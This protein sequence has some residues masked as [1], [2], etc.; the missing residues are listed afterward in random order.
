MQRRAQPSWPITAASAILACVLGP[1]PAFACEVTGCESIVSP[2]GHSFLRMAS[3]PRGR[4]GVSH[5][6][7]AA[8]LL[9]PQEQERLVALPEPLRNPS[10]GKVSN[11]GR[12]A[13]I[14]VRGQGLW[15][16]TPADGNAF[17]IVEGSV[18]LGDLASLD[19]LMYFS[20]DGGLLFINPLRGSPVAVGME[21]GELQNDIEPY[22]GM[23]LRENLMKSRIL[24][25]AE[26]DVLKLAG[27]H[28]AVELQ[29][30]RFIALIAR[31]AEIGR[32]PEL[33]RRAREVLDAF[34]QNAYLTPR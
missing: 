11:G 30:T 34:L 4:E 7:T 17:R 12:A 8:V 23:V 21:A 13:A 29:D 27:L 31:Y 10:L 26:D 3:D 16:W 24:L 14:L 6:P 2:D 22:Q 33:R 20:D 19:T 5:F 32:L 15:I 28:W 25:F 18:P 9:G 1:T